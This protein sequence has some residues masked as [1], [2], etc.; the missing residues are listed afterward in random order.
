MQYRA[1]IDYDLLQENDQPGGLGFRSDSYCIVAII[2]EGKA[3]ARKLREMRKMKRRMIN[4]Q[5]MRIYIQSTLIIMIVV[6]C[7]NHIIIQQIL[8][9]PDILYTII[10]NAAI[11]I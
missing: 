11:S 10:N 8:L 4:R 6:L 1:K 7:R 9:Q 3:R 5:D 2:K